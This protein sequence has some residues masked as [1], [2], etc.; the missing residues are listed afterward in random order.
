LS[1][2]YTVVDL[3]CMARRFAAGAR[4]RVGTVTPR[5]SW[6]ETLSTKVT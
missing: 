5:R 3:R 4:R 2:A 1:T 6:S